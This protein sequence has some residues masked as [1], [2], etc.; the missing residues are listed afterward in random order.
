MANWTTHEYVKSRDNNM[1]EFYNFYFQN[2]YLEIRMIISTVV[3][4]SNFLF[5]CFKVLVILTF[6]ILI[7]LIYKKK[8]QKNK[9]KISKLTEEIRR[10]YNANYY[11][12]FR[13]W[14]LSGQQ[15]I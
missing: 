13:K 9:K 11:L 15:I 6:L 4:I 8:K 5:R 2:G 3:G 10:F 14:N 12:G 1:N 7:L